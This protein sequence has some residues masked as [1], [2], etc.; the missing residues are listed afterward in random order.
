MI[1]GIFEFDSAGFELAM[2]LATR[3][4][5]LQRSPHF[6]LSSKT[7]ARIHFNQGCQNAKLNPPACAKESE[8]RGGSDTFKTAPVFIR[9]EPS[10]IRRD[11]NFEA[12]ALKTRATKIARKPH[13]KTKFIF[14]LS[15]I[16]K[17]MQIR[18]D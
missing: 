17:K 18:T 14:G 12:N 11:L 4:G 3:W 9:R 6:S 16:H 1:V 13:F 2:D 7:I 8:D 10:H 5:L 15:V